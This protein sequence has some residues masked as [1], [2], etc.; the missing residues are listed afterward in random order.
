MCMCLCQRVVAEPYVT[1]QPQV[2]TTEPPPCC[3]SDRML[4]STARNTNRAGVSHQTYFTSH[5]SLLGHR[6]R[7]ESS[8]PQNAIKATLVAPPCRLH[9]RD[10]LPGA[11]ERVGEEG[12]PARFLGLLLRGTSLLYSGSPTCSDGRTEGRRVKREL[13]PVNPFSSSLF[14]VILYEYTKPECFVSQNRVDQPCVRG[15][16]RCGSIAVSLRKLP[17]INVCTE[18]FTKPFLPLSI[19]AFSRVEACIV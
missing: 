4:S 17:C 9:N 5:R 11:H 18:E 14:W 8:E 3:S 10:Q 15:R 19:S 16:L 12:G 7:F 1:R 13:Q 2:A 6:H